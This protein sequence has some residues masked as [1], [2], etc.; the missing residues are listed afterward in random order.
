MT[1]VLYST[2]SR[3]DVLA[4][5]GLAGLFAIAASTL[6]SSAAEALV[7]SPVLD[8]PQVAPAHAP[9]AQLA[10][11]IVPEEGLD[12]RAE[13]IEFSDRRRRYWRGPRRRRRF[14]RRRYRR[15]V[16]RRRWYRGRLVRVC[17]RVW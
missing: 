10:E 8:P 1:R 4:G 3:R 7:N 6:G 13:A 17:R 16:C 12:H 9:G 5:F 2:P 11:L 14:W 15:L